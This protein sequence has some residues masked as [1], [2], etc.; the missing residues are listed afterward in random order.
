MGG[1]SPSRMTSRLVLPV[2]ITNACVVGGRFSKLQAS[3]NVAVP[4]RHM[5]SQ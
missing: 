2:G 5:R 3:G 4:F 1:L